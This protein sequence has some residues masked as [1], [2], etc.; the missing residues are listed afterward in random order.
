VAASNK[1]HGVHIQ[2]DGYGAPLFCRIGEEKIYRAKWHRGRLTPERT[3]V[4]EVSKVGCRF[5][6]RKDGFVNTITWKGNLIGIIIDYG[7]N[8]C[9]GGP[10]PKEKITGRKG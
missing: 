10:K 1:L 2:E 8:S 6:A 4:Q 9:T 3:L 7:L 5:V